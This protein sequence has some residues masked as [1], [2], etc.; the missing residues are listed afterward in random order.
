MKINIHVYRY[1]I[2]IQI[3]HSLLAYKSS[4][5]KNY[6][7]DWDVSINDK[8]DPTANV[9]ILYS[10]MSEDLSDITDKYNIVLYCNGGEPLMTMT[11]HVKNLL[12]NKDNVFLI[13]NSVLDESHDYF[14]KVIFHPSDLDL[15]KQN[16]LIKSYP[17]F[18]ENAN[19]KQLK[20]QNTITAIN[21]LNRTVRAFF[22]ESI[23]HLQL[24]KHENLSNN[25]V[26]TLDSFFET[27]E[28]FLFVNFL[29]KHYSKELETETDI[30]YTYYDQAI[31]IGP[32]N[33]EKKIL[34]IGYFI[35]PLY[36]QNSCVIFPETSWLNN[37]I[38][39]TEKS[40]KC[41]FAKCLPFV[42]GGANVNK[43]YNKIGFKTAWNLLPVE[44]QKFDSEIDHKK[45]YQQM[46]ESIEWLLTNTEVF[47]SEKFKQAVENN[48]NN[49]LMPN[50]DLLG[51][52]HLI[53][54]I[55]ERT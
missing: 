28:D 48:F 15:C 12:D 23:K 22:F 46:T 36:Y 37:E 32:S 53:K 43:I 3:V 42:V 31:K 35:L 52:K 45:R 24:E 49:F 25:I 18:Y 55:E 29:E 34:N 8:F 20:R 4:Q 47:E 33:Q 11:Q 51:L 16:W 6:S 7:S 19:T 40:L 27:P 39:I 13:S 2:G 44:L 41:F 30:D 50:S 54:V 26:K 9:N 38:S 17:Q 1:S 10:Y 21:G 14:D 5:A